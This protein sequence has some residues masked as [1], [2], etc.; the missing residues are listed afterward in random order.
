MATVADPL[1]RN[2]AFG[3]GF[4][5]RPDLRLRT[6]LEAVLLVRRAFPTGILRALRSALLR[7]SDSAPRWITGCK[8]VSRY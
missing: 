6:S 8:R 4:V 1:R 7:G 3:E 2:S 5:S